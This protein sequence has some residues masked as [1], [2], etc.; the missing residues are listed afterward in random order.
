MT[1]HMW[2][3]ARQH[4]ACCCQRC[5]LLETCLF[6]IC[7]GQE[8]VLG[9]QEQRPA[10]PS[11][12]PGLPQTQPSVSAAPAS[13]TTETSSQVATETPAAQEEAKA[14]TSS[15]AVAATNQAPAP[16]DPLSLGRQIHVFS[17]A[18]AADAEAMRGCGPCSSTGPC[19]LTCAFLHR[20]LL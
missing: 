13:T 10:T 2:R 5:L 15:S 12:Q 1:G 19:F 16:A 14:Q 4:R 20:H 8:R 6:H 7:A 18:A 3:Y 17:R 11:E 9:F